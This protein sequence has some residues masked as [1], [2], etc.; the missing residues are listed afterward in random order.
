MKEISKINKSKKNKDSLKIKTN[1][2]A[3]SLRKDSI[4]Q[5]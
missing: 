4:K 5:K 1:N 2:K 3:D